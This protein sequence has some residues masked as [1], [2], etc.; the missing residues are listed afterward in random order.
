MD[1]DDIRR[2]RIGSPDYE[3]W[4][5]AFEK[6]SEWHEWFL[7]LHPEQEKVVNADYVSAAQLS[8]VSGSG[9]TCVA[10]RRA[11]RLAQPSDAKVL[12]LTLNRSLARL[13][14][15]LVDAACGDE[16]QRSRIEVT[17]F[18]EL[19]QQLLQRFRAA[20]SSSLYRRHLET[21]RTR[22]RS[23]QGILPTMGE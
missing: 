18:F 2:L 20:K 19:A 22:R 16:A 15:Q 4:L 23:F 7:Y 8:G 1:G 14:D 12:L 17:S 3:A 11:M 5:T 6:R 21:R 9:K 10:V 13:L